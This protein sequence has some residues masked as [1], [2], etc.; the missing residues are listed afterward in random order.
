MKDG[1]EKQ[2]QANTRVSG[3]QDALQGMFLPGS[4]FLAAKTLTGKPA[5]ERTQKPRLDFSPPD[6][7]QPRLPKTTLL[8]LVD[9]PQQAIKPRNQPLS[10]SR[11]AC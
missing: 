9:S 2:A 7:V 4:T 11:R 3:W 5:V 6:R 10:A 8:K 1:V